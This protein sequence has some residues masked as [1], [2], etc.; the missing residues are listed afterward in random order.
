MKTEINADLQCIILINGSDVNVNANKTK[1]RV[2]QC[3]SEITV[4]QLLRAVYNHTHI[5]VYINKF[6]A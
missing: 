5:V 1:N 6:N 4:K 2:K 3:T